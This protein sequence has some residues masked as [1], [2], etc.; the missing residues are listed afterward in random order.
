MNPIDQAIILEEANRQAAQG[1]QGKRWISL[2]FR[3][4][5]GFD[6][7][8][9]I[10]MVAQGT[11]HLKQ[12][13]TSEKFWAKA[14]EWANWQGKYPM[15]RGKEDES[16]PGLCI[17]SNSGNMAPCTSISIGDTRD[18]NG[19]IVHVVWGMTGT[20]IYATGDMLIKM[21]CA[22]NRSPS[23]GADGIFYTKAT[24]TDMQ[25]GTTIQ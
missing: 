24:I 8:D 19:N 5:L 2:E 20:I 10:A 14:D 1:W 12:N 15:H 11:M 16:R 9:L 6:F 4:A 17:V 21:D 22:F 23:A 7:T 25:T 3:D 18:G 13:F